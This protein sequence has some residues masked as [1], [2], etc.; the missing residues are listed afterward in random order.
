MQWC[1]DGKIPRAGKRWWV[2][3]IRSPNCRTVL[4]VGLGRGV[5]YI[6]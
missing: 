2:H 3:V 5:L 4:S 6:G 1:P